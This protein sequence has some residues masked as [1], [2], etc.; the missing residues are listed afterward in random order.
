LFFF[1]FSNPTFDLY[2]TFFR[3]YVE[4]PDGVLQVIDLLDSG[5]GADSEKND[6]IYSR[7]YVDPIVNG[8]YNLLCVVNGSESSYVDDGNQQSN[9]TLGDFNRIQS[10]GTFRVKN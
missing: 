10:G 4:R 6:G 1:C 9:T 8:R 5:V 2:C 7:Y 3:A